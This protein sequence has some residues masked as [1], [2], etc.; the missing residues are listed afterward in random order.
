M[1]QELGEVSNI[2]W[3]ERQLLEL[4]VFKLEEEQL[5]LASGR[6]R[7][8]THA[9]R[10]VEAVLAEIKRLEL[11][12]SVHV[13]AL[14]QLL[15]TD[16]NPTLRTLVEVTETPWSGIF[17]EHRIALLELAQEIDGVARSNRDMLSRGQQAAREA[18]ATM[19]EIELDGYTGRGQSDAIVDRAAVLRLVDEAM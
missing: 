13:E 17:D 6:T 2:L 16:S 9:T 8:L 12:R 7:W 5:V 4:L 19:G 18:L 11:D 14:A 10:E 1:Q 15:G 3:R